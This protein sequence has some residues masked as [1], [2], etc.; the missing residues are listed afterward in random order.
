LSRRI[1]VAADGRTS[2]VALL[3]EALTA[4]H[5]APGARARARQLVMAGVVRVDGRMVRRPGWRP[6]AG[7]RIEAMVDAAQLRPVGPRHDRA[8]LLGPASILYEDAALI[9]VDKPAGIPTHATAD[10]ARPHLVGLVSALLAR[11]GGGGPS[12]GVHQRL[13]RETSGVLLLVKDGRANAGLGA[14]FA[15][16]AVRKLYL[17]LTARPRRLPPGRWVDSSPIGQPGEAQ[18]AE[19][20]FRLREVLPGA[21]LVEA[22]PRTGRKHQIRI[23][24]QRSGLPVLGEREHAAAGSRAGP[25]APRLMLH[26]LR[27][28][29]PH[30]LTGKPLSIESP[31][32]PDFS[33]LLGALGASG[34]RAAR[35]AGRRGPRG[36]RARP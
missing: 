31:L 35:G 15:R 10:P 8:L 4:T 7:A 33:A 27:L 14:A 9:A 19:T 26:A 30:P 12:L 3:A 2:L 25:R 24:L 23:H 20:E 36:R 16:G 1:A 13:D 29:L 5:G 17:A 18:A 34:A 11:R 6:G 21:L 32:P 22:R 28:E